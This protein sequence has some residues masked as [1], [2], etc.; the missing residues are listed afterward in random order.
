MMTSKEFEQAQLRLDIE[1][2][3]FSGKISVEMTD[4]EKEKFRRDLQA[5]FE[6]RD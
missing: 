1:E 5:Y 4:E 6:R 2:V 3:G